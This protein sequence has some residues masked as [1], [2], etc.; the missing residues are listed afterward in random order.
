M[1]TGTS[2][3]DVQRARPTRG[4]VVPTAATV[5]IGVA[6]M[7][8][9]LFVAG[10]SGGTLTDPVGARLWETAMWGVAASF[11][12]IGVLQSFRER[13]LSRVLLMTV[14]SASAFWQETYGD[15]GS[16]LLYSPAF[17]TY[18]WGETIWTSPV[19]CWWFIAGYVFFYVSFFLALE[20]AFYVV[21]DRWPNSNPYIMTTVVAF[22]MFYLFDLIVEGAAHGFGWWHYQYAFGPTIDVGYGH[23]P[24]VWP[25][26]EQVPFMALAVFA[27]TW[28]NRNGEDIF[29]LLAHKVLKR[30][31]GQ[32]A[33]LAS[34]IVT[35]NVT[36]L[37]TTILPL[38]VLRWLT[39]PAS[40]TV[41]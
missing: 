20:K 15:W 5:A 27:V 37:L 21:K 26:L 6:L 23:F 17:A 31:P 9:V 40:L 3:S 22:P 19:R 7:A 8:V 4:G 1:V 32:L 13:K 35:L 38:L 28:R 18:G 14:A 2:R 34:W 16:Y 30:R 25:I 24:L 36:F 29:E 41:P 39:G 10:H 11:L 33:I 12:T